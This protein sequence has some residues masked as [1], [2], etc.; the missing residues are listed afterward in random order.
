M[1]T[2]KNKILNS[3]ISIFMIGAVLFSSFGISLYLHTCK[4]TGLKTVS[5]L[6][7]ESCKTENI[8]LHKCCS[9]TENNSDSE[10]CNHS[11]DTNTHSQIKKDCCSSDEE[12]FSLPPGFLINKV[13]IIATDLVSKFKNSDIIANSEYIDKLKLYISNF[14]RKIIKPT[15]SLIKFIIQVSSSLNSEDKDSNS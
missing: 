8:S 14:E 15:K 11:D 12:S 4:T 7:A 6:T 2:T 1:F 10:E 5:I 13:Q 9:E 3:S